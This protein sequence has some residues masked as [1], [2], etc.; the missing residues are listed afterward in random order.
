VK[1]GGPCK[2][3]LHVMPASC[4]FLFVRIYGTLFRQSGEPVVRLSLLPR[5]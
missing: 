5:R 2:A 4:Q 1:T 3:P